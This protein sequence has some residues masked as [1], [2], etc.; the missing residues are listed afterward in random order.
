MEKV[1]SRH[2]VE[3][4]TNILSRDAM[5][6]NHLPLISIIIPMYNREQLI[7]DTI[8][9]VLN[10]TISEPFE[11]VVIDDGSNDNSAT[12]VSNIND[13]RIR[14]FYQPN[15]GAN[16]ARN[17]GLIKAKGRYVAFLDSDDQYCPEHLERCLET[18]NEEEN[19]V[20]YGQIIVDRGAGTSFVKPPRALRVDEAM[21][22]YLLCDRGFVQTSTLFLPRELACAVKY[23]EKLPFGQ[24][25]DFAIRLYDFGAQF[26]MLET[27][28][29][30]WRDFAD[31]KRVSSAS[32]ASIRES[33]LQRNEAILT[34]KAIVGDMGWFVAKAYARNRKYW[35]AGKL[36]SRAVLRG[37]YSSKLALTIACQIFLPPTL[38]RNLADLYIS[39]TKKKPNEN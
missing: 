3:Q 6:N 4:L 36:F 25:T 22:M 31:N 13:A 37:C 28:T 32:S 8:L 38:F 26:R 35:K 29:V 14:Y 2:Y 10:Q 20:V 5:E 1:I 15:S 17:H 11:I 27:P 24:D 39:K 34:K 33:W 16:I 7:A 21:C 23:D 19:T 9:S 18:I 12:V 30:I